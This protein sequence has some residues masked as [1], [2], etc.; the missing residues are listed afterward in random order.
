MQTCGQGRSQTFSFEGATGGA[1]FATR[2]AVSGLC[3]TF[4]KRP[5]KFWWAR[6]NFGGQWPPL[7]TRSSAPACGIYV[8]I[9]KVYF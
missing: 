1:S 9:V 8:F 4:K 2:G 6:Q 7:A 5:E 3:R